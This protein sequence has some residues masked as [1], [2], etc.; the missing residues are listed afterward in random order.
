[1]ADWLALSERE[2]RRFGLRV[3]RHP[4]ALPPPGPRAILAEMDVLGA[5]IAILRF[6]ASDRATTSALG[7][8]GIPPVH[9]DTLVYYGRLL[10]TTLRV[11]TSTVPNV[12]RAMPSDLE[13]VAH[14]ARL[15]FHGYRSHYDASACF[16]A[17]QVEAG[18]V[19][20]A[21]TH[22]QSA[23]PRDQTWLVEADGEPAGF[24]TMRTDHEHRSAEILLNAVLPQ[25]QGRGLYRTLVTQ[26]LLWNRDA[27]V[28]R[29]TVS[30]Q[31]W[32]IRVQRAWTALGFQLER[33]YNTYH[34]GKP[35]S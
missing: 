32:N 19:E 34:L 7:A 26:A 17:A 6:I 9:A 2:S 12:R 1:M 10:D 11:S 13:A 14:I 21:S 28:R 24:A 31:I 15:G 16:P 23:D 20:W 8:L 4:I 22:L 5:D 30:T 33:A 35:T 29:A 18:Y 25:H 3:A 27:G